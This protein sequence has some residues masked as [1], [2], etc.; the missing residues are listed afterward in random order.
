[1]FNQQKK[2]ISRSN[3]YYVIK[4]SLIG[5]ILNICLFSIKF[6]AGLY[7]NSITIIGDGINNLSDI[8]TTIVSCV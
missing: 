5:I 7:A 4:Y 3:T 1:M 8:G 6:A 2:C